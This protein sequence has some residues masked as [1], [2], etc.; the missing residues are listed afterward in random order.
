MG[1][2]QLPRFQLTVINHFDRCGIFKQAQ[3]VGMGGGTV[4]GFA[5]NSSST[6]YLQLLLVTGADDGS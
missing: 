4:W 6:L 2:R 5:P 1:F 3:R